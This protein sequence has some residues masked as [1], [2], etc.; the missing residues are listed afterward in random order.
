[1]AVI[2]LSN[3]GKVQE[4]RIKKLKEGKRR[5]PITAARY[6]VATARKLAPR[7]TGRLISSIRRSRNIVRIGGANSINGFPYVHWVNQTKG[8]KTLQAGRYT[9][10]KGIPHVSVNGNWVPVRGGKMIYGSAPANW[11]WTGT[12]RFV[13]IARN[14]A[15]QFFRNTMIRETRKAIM[16]QG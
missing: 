13:T 1:M 2:L 10:H 14:S 3:Y 12:P 5:G 11:N 15:R 9:D 6:M 7:K 4:L 8:F 16:I